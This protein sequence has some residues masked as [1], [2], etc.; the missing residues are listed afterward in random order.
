MN[1]SCAHALSALFDM[2][3]GM[4]NAV[5]MVPCM[6]F[7]RE[8]VPERFARM[9]E[10]IGLAGSS[11]EKAE[12]FMNWLQELK[13]E[14]DVPKG[15][16]DFSVELCQNLYEKSFADPCHGSNPRKCTV[17]DFEQLFKEAY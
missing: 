12:G 1:H 2:H 15:L 16:R 6:S 5:M 9:G 11:E 10:A 4:A 17:E 3:H 13:D 14:L 8:E 7:N